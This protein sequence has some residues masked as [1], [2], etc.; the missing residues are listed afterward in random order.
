LGVAR[1]PRSASA[2][3]KEPGTS[4]TVLDAFAETELSPAATMAGKVTNE[5]PPATAFMDAPT[6][7]ASARRRRVTSLKPSSSAKP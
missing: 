2:L 4:A 1:S 5:P 7:P 3:A 6:N